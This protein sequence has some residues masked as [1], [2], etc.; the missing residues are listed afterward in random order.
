MRRE[1]YRIKELLGDRVPS[2]MELFARMEDDI[3]Q[4]CIKHAKENPFRRYLEYLYDLGEISADEKVL[5]EGIGRSLFRLLKQQICKR[6][7]KCRS[8]MLFIIMEIYGWK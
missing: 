1:Y 2:R 5:Y 8:C 3:Y 4:Y 7:I 6:Y